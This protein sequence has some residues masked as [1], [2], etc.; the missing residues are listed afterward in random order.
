M[1]PTFFYI[2]AGIFGGIIGSFLN[3]VVLRD[4]RR[5]TILTGR[6][7]CMHCKHEL[8]WYELVPVLS[9]VLQLGRCRSCKKKLD[10]Q[11]PI[12]ELAVAGLAVFSIW[13]GYI[14]RNSWL[15]TFGVFSSLAVFF[16]ISASDFR[17]MEVRPEYAIIAAIVGGSS[18]IVT[19]NLTWLEVLYGLLLGSAAIVFFAYGWKALTG[20]LGMGEGDIWIIPALFLAI[21]IGAIVGVIFAAV[22]KKGL[23]IEMPFGPY[24]A[25]GGLLALVW[26][27]RILAWYI[28]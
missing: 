5:K 18:Q 24:L 3:V 25:L 28:L 26:G 22:A 14:D 23:A 1:S 12:G 9:F 2:V 15:L 27:Q 21:G 13:Y 11:Y 19:G 8:Q 4:D 16:V 7:E 20:K 10:W 17:T 6:S